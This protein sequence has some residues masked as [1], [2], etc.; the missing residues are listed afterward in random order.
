MPSGVRKRDGSVRV[1]QKD[2]RRERGSFSLRSPACRPVAERRCRV[3]TISHSAENPLVPSLS[4]APFL[5][6][7]CK[8]VLWWIWF[9]LC[10]YVYGLCLLVSHGDFKIDFIDTME[11]Y[12]D[13]LLR[14]E[15]APL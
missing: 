5:F 11:N 13:F 9:F 3:M 2:A 7:I 12:L 1:G 15:L 14:K 4:A 10:S 8:P 6:M